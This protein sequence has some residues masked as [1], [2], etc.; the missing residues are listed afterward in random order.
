MHGSAIP[1]PSKRLDINRSELM[2]LKCPWP[3]WLW[4]CVDMVGLVYMKE[5]WRLMGAG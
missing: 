4:L 3:C 1:L 2:C 5:S